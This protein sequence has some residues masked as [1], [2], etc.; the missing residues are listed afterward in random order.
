MNR[1]KRHHGIFLAETV[2]SMALVGILVAILSVS[3]HQQIVNSQRLNESRSALSLA[4]QTLTAL[5]TG[6][7]P[8]KVPPRASVTIQH[9]QAPTPPAG[10]LWADVRVQ[11]NGREEQVIGLIRAGDSAKGEAR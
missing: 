11:L 9:L 5:Q 6:T 7:Q 10:R 8:P 3:V 4:E 1:A 2:V